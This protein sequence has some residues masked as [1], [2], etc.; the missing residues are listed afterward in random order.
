MLNRRLTLIVFLILPFAHTYAGTGYEV[1]AKKSDGE[2]L[3]YQVKFGGGRQFDQFTAF[4]PTSKSFVYLTWNRRETAPEPVSTIFDH[5]TGK[6][7]PLY[8]F[9]EAKHPLPVIPS[10]EE[11]KVSP[12]TG[13]Q[14]FKATRRIAYD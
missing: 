11:M 5:T 14:A 2:T 3:T 10:M 6:T 8:K 4:D 1:Q 12:L 7:I 13:D 9:P